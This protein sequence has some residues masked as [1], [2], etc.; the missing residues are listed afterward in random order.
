MQICICICGRLKMDRSRS[1]SR[2]QELLV[3]WSDS[4]SDSW[5]DKE[6]PTYDPLSHSAKKQ[7]SH[8]RLA[9]NAIHVIPLV[10]VL[11]AVILWFFSN[12]AVSHP[13]QL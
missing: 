10:V 3:K 12:P 7:R 5:R 1:R 2:S 6:L 4:D 13:N 8:L 9:Q 11:C